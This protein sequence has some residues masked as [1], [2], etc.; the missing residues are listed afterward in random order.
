MPSN[1]VKLSLAVYVLQFSSQEQLSVLTC[2]AHVSE[3]Q[4]KD[5]SDGA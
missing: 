4:T 2:S 5:L 1:C 3:V